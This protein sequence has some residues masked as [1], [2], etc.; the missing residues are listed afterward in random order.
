LA[1][2]LVKNGAVLELPGGI[3]GFILLK[4]FSWKERI[5]HPSDVLREGDEVQV[6]ILEINPSEQKIYLGLKQMQEN[7]FKDYESGRIVKCAVTGTTHDR[8]LVDLKD[9]IKGFIHIS[10]V[11]NEKT[12]NLEG[13][14]PGM[15][16]EAVVIKVNENSRMVELSI[17]ELLNQKENETMQQ[18]Y[19][20]P[21]SGF[22][23]G[24]I[25]KKE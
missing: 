22:S 10:Q 8:I 9:D 7:P 12:E 16:I 19:S 5:Q 25:L 2:R 13:F 20:S 18:Y 24:D 15:Q 4:D 21:S 23:I 14:T 17:R 6:K 1:T 11:A 3:E